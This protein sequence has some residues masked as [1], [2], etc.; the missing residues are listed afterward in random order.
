MRVRVRD[1][2]GDPRFSAAYYDL[3]SVGLPHSQQPGMGILPHSQRYKFA[4]RYAPAA[5]KE[6]KP[7]A[8]RL[9]S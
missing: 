6:Q 2:C 8:K 9:V 7:E 4:V 5:V 3:S 1:E